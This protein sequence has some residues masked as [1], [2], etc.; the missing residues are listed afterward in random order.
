M[1]KKLCVDELKEAVREGWQ[2]L[3]YDELYEAHRVIV[4]A[5][6][7]NALRDTLEDIGL[8]LVKKLS[9]PEAAAPELPF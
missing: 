5:E 2:K 9:E 6:Y 7:Q 3:T 4:L 8:Q 1:P